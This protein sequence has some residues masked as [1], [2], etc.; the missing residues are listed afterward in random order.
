MKK[1]WVFWSI[2][3]NFA[4]RKLQF[5]HC[6]WFLP[7]QFGLSKLEKNL[8]VFLNSLKWPR[9]SHLHLT[10]Y[11]MPYSEM[12]VCGL[13]WTSISIHVPVC[14]GPAKPANRSHKGNSSTYCFLKRVLVPPSSMRIAFSKCTRD[15]ATWLMP[16]VCLMK[17][18]IEMIS[19]GIPWLK[20]IWNRGTTESP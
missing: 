9:A 16:G 6:W 2:L 3:R 15:V 4:W 18:L 19:R 13:P 20:V 8:W 1:A 10:M 5:S 17:C 14:W 12:D 7:V 11:Q